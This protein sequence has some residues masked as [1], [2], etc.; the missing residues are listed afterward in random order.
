MLGVDNKFNG[1]VLRGNIGIKGMR[2]SR[3]ISMIKYRKRASSI[4]DNSLVK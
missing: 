2:Q 3:L 4:E 1:L